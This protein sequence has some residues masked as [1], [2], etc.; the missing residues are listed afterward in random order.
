MGKGQVGKGP[1]LAGCCRGG[2]KENPAGV[3][4]KRTPPVW[5][6]LC[7]LMCSSMGPGI[8][9]YD[10]DAFFAIGLQERVVRIEFGDQ[11]VDVFDGADVEGL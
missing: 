8:E 10:L 2:A 7:F 6:G 5:R 11:D 9:L 1:P 3:G 4:Q